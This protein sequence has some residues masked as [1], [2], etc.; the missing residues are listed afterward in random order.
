MKE[1]LGIFT[2]HYSIGK[3]ILTLDEPAEINTNKPVSIFSILKKYEIQ[4]L[5]LVENTFSGFIEAYKNSKD[6]NINLRFGIKLI[7]C[8]DMNDKSENSRN[9]ESKIII[10]MKN[11]EGYKDLIKI[12]TKAA[13]EGSYYKPR[14]SWPILNE[15]ITKNLSLSI[16]AHSSFLHNNILKGHQCIP[17]FN[18]TKPNIMVADMNLP[19]DYIIQQAHLE[20]AKNN[21][22]EINEVHPIYY[23]NNENFKAYNVFQCIQ[24]RSTYDKPQ[25]DHLASKNFSFEKYMEKIGRKP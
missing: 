2:S 14:I 23:Y 25:I 9:T 11:S 3:S 10:W 15:M 24:N 22:L 4:N 16:P 18:K 19:F 7:V 12:Y 1:I 8:D 20:Y 17:I 21:K 6:N 13:T 5:Y